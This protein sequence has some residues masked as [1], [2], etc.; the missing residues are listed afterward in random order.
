MG[1]FQTSTIVYA[2]EVAPTSVRP[3]LTSWASQ[4]WV[5]GQTLCA[6]VARSVLSVHGSWAYRIPF[7]V[8]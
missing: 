3:M 1:I 8:Q 5:V 6:V 7:A 2:A 4:M